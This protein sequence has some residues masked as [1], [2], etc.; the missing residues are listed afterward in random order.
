MSTSSS[1]RSEIIFYDIALRPP[2]EKTCCSPNP[3]KTRFALNF[4]NVPYSTT[5]VPLPDVAKVRSTLQLPACRTFADGTEFMTLPIIQDPSTDSLVG[6]SF[7]IAV[8][9]QETYPDT[10]AGDLFPEQNLDYTPTE[11]LAVAVPLTDRRGGS[12]PDYAD[13][14]MNVDAA[15]TAHVQLCFERFPFDPA[16][17]EISRADFV[18][19]AGGKLPWEDL[20]L[21]GKPRDQL[22][23]SF[24]NTLGGLSKLFLR[25]TSGPFILGTRATYA[26]LIVGAW[27]RMMSGSLPDD[28]W[29]EL[30]SWHSEVFGK[31]HDALEGYAQVK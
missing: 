16:T 25:D 9:L 10:G 13:F 21:I 2:V 3:W 5:W 18:R 20:A 8:Y 28:E 27:L 1:S 23:D 29:Q 19:R 15:F 12:F 30:R 11:D 24:R 7:D 26:D 4:K 17:A 6:D 22:K 31:L 14:N